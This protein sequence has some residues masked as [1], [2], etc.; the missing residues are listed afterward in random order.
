MKLR[1]RH[2]YVIAIVVAMQLVGDPDI[3]IWL[4]K[5]PRFDWDDGN[6]TKSQAKHGFSTADV[7]SLLDAPILFAGQIVEPAHE[8]ARYLLLVRY[9]TRAARSPGLRQARR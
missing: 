2:S 1:L 5:R 3:A 7:E 6:S 4:G 9:S 8:E